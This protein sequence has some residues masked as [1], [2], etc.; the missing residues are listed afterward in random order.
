MREPA[1]IRLADKLANLPES[2][3]VYLMRDKH[4][5]VIYVGKAKSLR[6]RVRSYFSGADTRRFVA[7]LDH[8]LEDLEV[9]LTHSEKEALLL[10]NELIKTHHP[11]FNVKLTDDKRFLCL[12][13]DVSKPYPRLEVVR[14]FGKD[15]ARYF[16]PFHSASAIRE[17]LRLIN[18]HFQLRTCT[19]QMMN[20]RSRPCLQYQIK[21]CPGPCVYDLSQGPYA[22]N[23]RD[24]VAFLEGRHQDLVQDLTARME[25]AAE[26]LEF[27]VAGAL[28]DQLK[29]VN[30]SME[31]QRLVTPDF[32]DRDVVGLYREG[33]AIEIHL[34]RT[35]SGRPSDAKRFTLNDTE[36]PTEEVLSEFATLYY[37]GDEPVPDEIV[38]GSAMVWDQA[39]QQLLQER[40][41]RAV[42]VL[43]PK[44]GDKKRLVEMADKNAQQ[45][46]MDKAREAGAAKSAVEA[47]KRSLRLKQAPETI[48]CMDISHI[49]GTHIVASVVHFAQ[50]VAHK[51]MYRHYKIR[52][53]TTQDD[54]K[55][56][57]EVVGRRLQRGLEEGNLPNLMVI[58]GGKGQLGA[59]QAALRDHNV[60]TVELISLAKSRRL[61]DAPELTLPMQDALD[62]SAVPHETAEGDSTQ[63]LPQL[64]DSI[65]S[66]KGDSAQRS[67]ERV[68][69][70]GHKEPIVLKQNSAELF[71]LV[72]LRDEAHRFAIS[73]H[74]KLRQK[75]ATRSALDDIPGVGPKRR[76]QLLRTFGSVTAL[77]QADEA[78]VAKEVGPKLAQ[79]ICEALRRG[80]VGAS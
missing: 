16:G 4:G 59:A 73:F 36:V 48:E 67:A 74:R 54:F 57:Y 79:V 24:V 66:P 11:R 49:M 50:G 72:R 80:R 41:G 33:P 63:P 76:R 20:N 28:R 55:S 65:S 58:D 8:W 68:F 15:K 17:S 10:E 71:L 7:T 6:D 42:R 77:R 22:A 23:V 53:T 43:V 38:F 3:G 5:T 61:E 51:P 35:R 56:M 40:A 39:L 78:A 62:P 75:A 21:R 44:R 13:L 26:E 14:R 34:L 32:V 25:A 37:T 27:E 29:A 1:A 18:R 9:V 64:E 45:A 70:L 60:D 52:T 46:F 12:R 69:V 31:R 19:D 2:P 47:L 30:R